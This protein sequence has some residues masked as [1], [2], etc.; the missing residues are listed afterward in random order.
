MIVPVT[1]ELT[2][3]V[4]CVVPPRGAAVGAVVIVKVVG[5]SEA[6]PCMVMLWVA[7]LAFSALSV[8]TM[9]PPMLPAAIGLN[10]MP[11]TQLAAGFKT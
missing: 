8:R 10:S 7:E 9:L 1:V 2:K 11:S 4:N 3:A 6:A 5:A